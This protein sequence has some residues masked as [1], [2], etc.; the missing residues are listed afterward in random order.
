M[1]RDMDLVREILLKIEKAKPFE[2]IRDLKI[3]GYDKSKI[4]YHC[5]LLYRA[6]FIK[7]YEAIG[8]DNLDVPVSFWVQDLTWEGQDFLETIREK[9]IWDNTKKVISEKG[10]PMVV[11]TIK[12]IA[13]AF[14]TAAAEG[15]AN[16]IIKNGGLGNAD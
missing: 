8:I 4:A 5:E 7:K 16:S 10:L 11:G 14:I 15:V 13:S 3:D 2:E 12:T 9:T 1:K 6:N